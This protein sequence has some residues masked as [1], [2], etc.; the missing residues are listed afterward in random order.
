MTVERESGIMARFKMYYTHFGWDLS[1]LH[2]LNSHSF[3]KYKVSSR[4]YFFIC[5][6]TTRQSIS[7]HYK[8]DCHTQPIKFSLFWW[9]F[10]LHVIKSFISRISHVPTKHFLK[11]T[12]TPNYSLMIW[13]NLLRCYREMK[14]M[15]S[16]NICLFL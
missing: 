5:Y 1:T 16:K 11:T 9:I 15:N 6:L 2:I 4:F 12:P 14:S 13:F 8:R 3:I 7:G 10:D